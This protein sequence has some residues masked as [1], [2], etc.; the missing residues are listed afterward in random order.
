MDKDFNYEKWRGQYYNKEVVDLKK[1]FT[2]NEF[3]MLEN[4]KIKIKDKIYTEYEFELLNMEL[5][6]YYED[7]DMSEEELEMVKTLEGTGVTKYEYNKLVKK[8]EEINKL[9]NF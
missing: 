6:A 1:H 3:K 9:Y 2:E 8:C 7:D 4:L 5:L